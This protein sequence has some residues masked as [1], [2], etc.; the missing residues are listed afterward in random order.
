LETIVEVES[1]VISFVV[2]NENTIK[3]EEVK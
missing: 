3:L 2:Y 1:I